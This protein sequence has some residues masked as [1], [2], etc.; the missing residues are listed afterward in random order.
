MHRVS[1]RQRRRGHYCWCCGRFRSNESFSGGGHAR[2]LC[3]ACSRLGSAELAVQQALRDVCRLVGPSGILRGRNVPRLEPFALHEDARVRNAASA[4]LARYHRERDA[5][6]ED[7]RLVDEE[8]E[9]WEAAAL[10]EAED[11]AASGADEDDREIP[12]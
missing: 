5:L 10:I 1:K 12:F 11:Y 9:R 2:H 6:L 7:R 3:K 4:L 8:A